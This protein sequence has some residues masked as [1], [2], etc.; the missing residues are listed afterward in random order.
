MVIADHFPKETSHGW[1]F[2]A[3]G[4][5]GKLYVPVGAPCN[6][7][8]P[9]PDRYALIGRLN[10]DG[11]GYEIVARGVRNSVGFD[12]DPNTHDLWFTDN[13]RD[14][15]GD[16]QPPDELNHATKPGCTSAIPIAMGERSRILST[17]ANMLAENSRS[18]RRTG[19]SRRPPGH[20]LLHRHHVP[21]G[22]PESN[23]YRRAWIL[24]SERE[25]RLSDHAC[26]TR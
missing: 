10:P 22:I 11:S 2:I 17:V 5:D 26:V 24:E 15:L 13:G 4:P 9:D 12:W 8:E 23:F 20:A 1:K 18:R 7:C 14:H 21:Q 6:I 19:S 3:F 16:N 25:N